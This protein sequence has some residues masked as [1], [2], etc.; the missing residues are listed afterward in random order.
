MV[1]G[2]H[3]SERSQNLPE[4]DGEINRFKIASIYAAHTKA[5]TFS[6]K[7]NEPRWNVNPSHLFTRLLA[8]TVPW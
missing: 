6:Q 2:N 8:L 3:S 1:E 4:M 5:N 7:I